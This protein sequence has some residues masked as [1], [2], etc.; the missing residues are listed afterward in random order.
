MA[1]H[2]SVKGGGPKAGW[3]SAKRRGRGWSGSPYGRKSVAQ[4]RPARHD[5]AVHDEPANETVTVRCRWCGRRFATP[6][7]VDRATLE[8]LVLTETYI[9]PRCGES[10]VYVKSD[11]VPELVEGP[12][13]LGRPG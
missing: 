2:E 12:V 1:V 13:P 7:Q 8:S 9:C 4:T 10:A 3:K 5:E 6:L 11:H